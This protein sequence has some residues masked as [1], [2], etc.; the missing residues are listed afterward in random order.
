M[1]TDGPPFEIPDDDPIDPAILE[2]MRQALEEQV[3]TDHGP[4]AALRSWPT[5]LRRTAFGLLIGALTLLA[6]LGGGGSLPIALA[7]GLA[8]MALAWMS[9]RPLHRPAPPSWAEHIVPLASLGTLTT[10]AFATGTGGETAWSQHLRCFG[11]GIAVGAAT[12]GVW[13]LLV[14][15]PTGFQAFAAASAAGIAANAFLAARCTL[16]STEHLLLGHASVLASLVALVW[17][18][19]LLRQRTPAT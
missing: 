15:Q 14:R 8:A 4:L 16:A 1:S 2:S 17:A 9:L 13:R 11:P 19:D 18:A 3:R 12:L 10:I 7:L 5:A 6:T